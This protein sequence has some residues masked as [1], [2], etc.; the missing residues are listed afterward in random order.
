MGRFLYSTLIGWAGLLA[1]SAFAFAGE[2]VLEFKFV[3]KLLDPR[4]SKPQ[5]SPVRR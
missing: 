1:A 3:I 4:F 5:I 2:Q